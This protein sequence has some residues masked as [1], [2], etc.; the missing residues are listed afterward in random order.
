MG[1][2]R[3]DRGLQQSVASVL[4][5]APRRLGRS[6]RL[7]LPL[8]RPRL[9]RRPLAALPALA[10]ARR[11]RARARAPR[12][13]AVA[14][15]AL[16]AHRRRAAPPRLLGRCSLGPAGL[17]HLDVG[18]VALAASDGSTG[19]VN[20]ARCSASASLTVRLALAMRS[21]TAAA[22]LISAAS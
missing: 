13:L 14:A 15:L 8:V 5:A 21:V 9:R 3:A 16:T 6:P 10:A 11:A 2:F 22:P 1:P 4:P 17:G 7:H 20:P 12:L 18:A 19:T